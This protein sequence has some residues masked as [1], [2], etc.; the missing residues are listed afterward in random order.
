VITPA[1]AEQFVRRHARR[2]LTTRHTPL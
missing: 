1:E 2:G